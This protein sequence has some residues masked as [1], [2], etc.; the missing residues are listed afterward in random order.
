VSQRTAVFNIFREIPK[1]EFK[2]RALIDQPETGA[3]PSYRTKEGGV[4]L[5]AA[6]PSGT[7][8]T[9][10]V[11]IITV[12][13][14]G[15][16]YLEQTI[17][18]V[19]DH[20]NGV[21]EYIVIDGASDDGTL[22]IISANEECIDYWL[23]EPDSG[24]FAAMNKGIARSTGKYLLFLNARDMLVADIGQ[25]RDILTLDFVLVYGKANMLE[26]DG[27]LSYVKGRTLRSYRELHKGMRICH[28]AIFFRRDWIGFYDTTYRLLADRV[29]VHDII[30]S[31][32]IDRTRFIDLPIADYFEGGI[33]R[34]CFNLLKEEEFRFLRS[35]GR[36]FYAFYRNIG[37]LFRKNLKEPWRA[38]V[39]HYSP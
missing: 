26:P 38:F 11:S 12:V 15:A 14:N 5:R 18:S 34:Q 32:G 33:S 9:P 37:W 27:K 30:R 35:I 16:D 29:K 25:L 7:R 23:S 31:H 22:E 8:G 24:I 1:Q 2:M 17:R 21:A 20:R 19:R 3:Q 28:Q 39:K 36:G 6:Q 13:R 4:R 10:L